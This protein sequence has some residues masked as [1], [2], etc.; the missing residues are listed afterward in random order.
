M[1]KP[2]EVNLFSYGTLQLEKIQKELFGKTLQGSSD[3][4]RGYRT[5]TIKIK[6]EAFPSASEQQYLIALPSGDKNDSVK[7][8]VYKITEEELL[9]ADEYES[10]DY[11][12]IK[13]VLESGIEA[14][15][16]V[17]AE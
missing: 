6:D 17:A 2:M 5:S 13:V 8:T 10:A 7:G 4:L 9:I 3:V 15:I 16:Y 1:K 12:R 14:W 11:K